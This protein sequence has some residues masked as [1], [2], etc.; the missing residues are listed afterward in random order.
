[1]IYLLAYA[2]GLLTLINPCILPVLPIVLASAL[3]GHRRG[4]LALAGG[5]IVAFVAFGLG[6]AVIGQSLGLT[7][8][9]LSRAGAW[10]MVAFGVVLLVPQFANRFELATAGFASRANSGIDQV[11]QTTLSGQALTGALLGAVWSPCVGPAL[12]GAISLSY[13]GKNLLHAG[14][15]MFA[16]ALGVATLILALSFGTREALRRR[17]DSLRRIANWSRP[18]M[19][20]V[21]LLVGG[22]ILSGAMNRLEGWTLN[23]MPAWLQELSVA[24]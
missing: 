18:I 7:S 23:N 2:A 22:A 20:I 21:L 15:I 24:L 13:Q 14:V 6:I 19:G 8:D 16:F 11:N 5:M 17:Q 1:M 4:P 12:G 9:D 10:M 3:Q